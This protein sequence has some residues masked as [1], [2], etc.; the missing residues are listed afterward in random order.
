MNQW[1]LGMLFAG[2]SF[3]GMVLM[4]ELGRHYRQRR[5]VRHGG[6]GGGTGLGA[7]EGAVFALMGL[8]VAF[9]FS[10]AAS[11]LEGRRQLIVE[12]ANNIGTAYL[13]LDLLPPEP[14][15][16][17]QEKLRRYT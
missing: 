2:S 4:V 13:R 5:V 12:E 8:L 1:I 9:T 10:G 15:A 6:V 14:R 17:L 11:R 7:V 3:M 16:D